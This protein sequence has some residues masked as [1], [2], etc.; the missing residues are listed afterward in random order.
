MSS[1]ETVYDYTNVADNETE[2]SPAVKEVDVGRCTGT[3]SGGQT[4]KCLF[5][6]QADPNKCLA[7]LYGK[8]SSCTPSHFKVHRYTTKERQA[9][10]I[11]SITDCKCM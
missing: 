4:R 1:L 5:R 11:I 9:K 8:Q 3:C 2:T 7:G 10:E 6:D